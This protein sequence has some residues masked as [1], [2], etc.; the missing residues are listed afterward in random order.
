MRAKSPK[1]KRYGPG[2]R[3]PVQAQQMWL[4]LVGFVGF[5]A[6]RKTYTYGELAQQMGR[7]PQAGHMLG[8]QLGI[9][10]HYC[11]ENDLPPLNSIVVDKDSGKPGRSV[12]TTPGRTPA[13]DQAAVHKFD[14]FSVRVPSAGSLRLIWESM[15]K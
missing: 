5:K 7:S 14:W 11:L 1:A 9:I 13:Q 8:R 2:D 6:E 12:L 15:D 4:I 3:L 10:G